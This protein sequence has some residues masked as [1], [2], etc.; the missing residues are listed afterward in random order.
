MSKIQCGDKLKVFTRTRT[1]WKTKECTV[2]EETEKFISVN[3]GLYPGCINKF[4][5]KTGKVK[6]KKIGTEENGMRKEEVKD[7]EI[8][9]NGAKGKLSL[10]IIGVTL[11]G[12]N[13][14]YTVCKEGIELKSEEQT[15]AFQNVQQ[16]EDFKA[17]IDRVFEYGTEN[18]ILAS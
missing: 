17:E 8:E 13:G 1:G 16:W 9:F 6:I 5:L 4:D 15:L 10:D 7:K 3:Y 14:T 11:S 12:E 18:K 2:V